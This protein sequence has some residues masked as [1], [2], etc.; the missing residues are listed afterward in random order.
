[1]LIDDILNLWGRLDIWVAV[2]ESLTVIDG[3]TQEFWAQQ[4]SMIQHPRIYYTAST[5]MPAGRSGPSNMR[6]QQCRKPVQKEIIQTQLPNQLP[7]DPSS[8]SPPQLQFMA[9]CGDQRTQ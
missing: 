6:L 8:L 2:N 9:E 4:P 5:L 3:R 7:M 1:M